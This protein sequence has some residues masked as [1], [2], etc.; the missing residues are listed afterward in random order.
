M[1]TGFIILVTNHSGYGGDIQLAVGVSL[2]Y[3]I[4]GIAFLTINET[5]G[6]GMEAQNKE[7]LDQFIGK[8]VLQYSYTK[9]GSTSDSEIDALS[10][11]TITT[12]AV[13]D[14]VNTA[15]NFIGGIQ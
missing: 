4:K 2:D 8:Q 15:L 10:G 14:A 13:V 5:A 7:F 1:F 12:S 11:A 6:L 9:T 3:S